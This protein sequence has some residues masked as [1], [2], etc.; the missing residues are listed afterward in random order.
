[1]SKNIIIGLVLAVIWASSLALFGKHQYDMGVQITESA[2]NKKEN[3]EL[4]A[5]NAEIVKLRDALVKAEAEKATAL[6]EVTKTYQEKEKDA[7]DQYQ[8]NLMDLRARL[9]RMYDPG[10]RSSDATTQYA[11]DTA[12]SAH[13][14]HGTTYSELS[15]EAS[16][17]LLSLTAEA[18]SVTRQLSLCQST[19]TTYLTPVSGT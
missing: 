8:K 3:D 9:L 7:Q 19:I 4:K 1:M 14:C 11:A 13:S 16:E 12:S 18:D 15:R 2:W 6:A 10:T 17:F 5:A